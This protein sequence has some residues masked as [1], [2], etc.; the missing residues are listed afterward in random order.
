VRLHSS[1]QEILH[2]SLESLK[3]RAQMA[4]R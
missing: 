3:F 1:A 4:I 2:R